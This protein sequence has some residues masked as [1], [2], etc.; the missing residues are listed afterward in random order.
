[1]DIKNK[2]GVVSLLCLSFLMLASCFHDED[3]NVSV[4]VLNGTWYGF[5][6][7]FSSGDVS[8]VSYV[9]SNGT[10]SEVQREN[11]GTNLLEDQGLVGSIVVT[12]N[13]VFSYELN[14]RSLG[15]FFSD[16]GHDFI[17]Y[18]DD[19]FNFGVLQKGAAEDLN[20][21]FDANDIARNWTGYGVNVR[22]GTMTVA[23]KYDS[24]LNVEIDTQNF[25]GTEDA[26]SVSEGQYTGSF[27]LSD[28]IRGVY[29]DSNWT[30]PINVDVFGDITVILSPDKTYAGARIC[31]PVVGPANIESC[32]FM[33]LQ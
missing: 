19:Q 15:D 26:D 29:K 28:N 27:N 24:D 7:N 6:E 25:V 3:R 9:I 21:L 5:E 23:I 14:N 22:N 2:S 11:Q 16:D 13:N 4:S 30:N 10:I 8:K 17:T 18:V 32:S 20:L 1:M 12:T 31:L 33:S